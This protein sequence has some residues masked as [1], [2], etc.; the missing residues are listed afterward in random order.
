MGAK[1]DQHGQQ[2]NSTLQTNLNATGTT[3][4]DKSGT[5]STTV[6][7]SA[8][9]STAALTTGL[10]TMPGAAKT[11]GEETSEELKT[12][13]FNWGKFLVEALGQAFYLAVKSMPLIGGLAQQPEWSG[14]YA[15]G[16]RVARTGLALMH[17]GDWVRSSFGD[18]T[19]TGTG[20]G[21]QNSGG[22]SGFTLQ[23]DL[24]IYSQATDAAG[25]K[26]DILRELGSM[27][28]RA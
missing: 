8:D 16:G 11:A 21:V 19:R 4:A 27:A 12:Q 25:I 14:S 13:G 20:G 10:A 22:G 28:R 3:L 5:W 2:W 18:T 9:A 6:G 1:I 17:E 15:T 23:G 26:R 7:T 24:N